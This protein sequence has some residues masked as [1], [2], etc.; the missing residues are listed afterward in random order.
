MKNIL[1]QY[2]NLFDDPTLSRSARR[3]FASLP[4]TALKSPFSCV[5]K[6]PFRYGFRA[7]ARAF[8]YSVVIALD[9]CFG[10]DRE[11]IKK[12]LKYSYT[13]L[14][15]SVEEAWSELTTKVYS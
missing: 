14:F 4:E 12:S 10:N 2:K 8:R 3:S 15:L 13:L 7:G 5:N 6:R 11:K 9:E 1:A